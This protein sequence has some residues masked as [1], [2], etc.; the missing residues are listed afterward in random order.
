MRP[1]LHMAVA[2]I[3]LVVATWA[4]CFLF[5]IIAPVPDW[6]NIPMVVTAIAFYG[7]HL[8]NIVWAMTRLEE[9]V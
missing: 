3:G 5:H 1:S 6:M 4:G 8:A 9:S 2:T 7:S